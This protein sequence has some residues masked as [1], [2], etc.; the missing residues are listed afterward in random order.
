MSD[1]VPDL[2]NPLTEEQLA[3]MKA[4]QANIVNVRKA[5]KKAKR[6]GIDVS[7]QEAQLNASETQLTRLLEVY[8]V[9]TRGN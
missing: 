8:S 4:Q 3:D 5:L 9:P 6:A 2:L 1:N 7:E